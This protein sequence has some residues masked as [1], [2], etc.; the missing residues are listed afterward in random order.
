MTIS[1]EYFIH[2]ATSFFLDSVIIILRICIWALI[3][4]QNCRDNLCNKII[5]V[6]TIT[7][8]AE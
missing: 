5:M 7:S 1:F 2:P 8:V 4:I 6:E 3:V